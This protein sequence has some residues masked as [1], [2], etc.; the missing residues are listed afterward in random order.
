MVV[1]DSSALGIYLERKAGKGKRFPR[2]EQGILSVQRCYRGFKHC[3]EESC[4]V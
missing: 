4:C 3:V 2:E 1:V